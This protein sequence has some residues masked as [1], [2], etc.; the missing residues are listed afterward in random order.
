MSETESEGDRLHRLNRWRMALGRHA[1]DLGGGL[2]ERDARI[3]GALEVVYGRGL[4]RR[5]QSGTLDPS[6]IALPE[7]LA[8]MRRLFPRS[9]FEAVQGHAIDRFGMS[10]L[11]ADPE[12][13]ARLEPNRDLMKVLLTFKGRI[14]PRLAD[15]ARKIVAEVV[16]E[17]VR[18]LKPRMERSLSGR[19][20]R[21]RA[22]GLR[23]AADFD[24]AG[25]V[26]SN[27]AH[28]DPQTRRLVPQRL[29]FNGRQSRRLPFT[30]ILCVDQS[31]SML[32]S[33]VHA[34]VMASIMARL[35]GVEVRFV[36]FDTAVVDLSDR[37]DDPIDLL[38]AVQLGGGT[39]IGAALA[40]CES[41][42][43]QPSRTVLALVSD[44]CE[45]AS[46]AR[47]VAAVRRLNEARVVTLGLAAL[48]EAATPVYDRAIAARL[49]DAGMQ[50]AALTP[51]RFAEWLADIIA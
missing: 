36:V 35:P 25:T 40:Y 20:R 38:F 48:D 16:D 37:L 19:R 4:G 43:T 21:H 49:A 3:D 39:N 12:L 5:S 6:Q 18:R 30:V 1:G 26:R 42:I 44:F 23:S 46:V 2:S 17:I 29:R 51:D 33:L 45:G 47:L 22:V 50:V 11:L 34:T 10:D 14:D 13:L 8:D 15:M 7:W 24:L 41:L 27:L 9:V 31:G 32:M 28:Y